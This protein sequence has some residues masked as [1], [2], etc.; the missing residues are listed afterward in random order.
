M[1]TGTATDTGRGWGRPRPRAPLLLFSPHLLRG[2][3]PRSGGRASPASPRPPCV[4]VHCTH[5]AAP[6][7]GAG[8]WGG[9]VCTS[10]D[11]SSHPSSVRCPASTGVAPPPRNAQ[12]VQAAAVRRGS[13]GERSGG[14]GRANRG[15]E[16]A[17]GERRGRGG[18]VVTEG[19]AGW[20]SAERPAATAVAHHT[21]T[22]QCQARPDDLWMEK[23]GGCGGRSRSPDD[24][25]TGAHRCRRKERG[26]ATHRAPLWG[27]ASPTQPRSVR[28]LAR[29]GGGEAR[30]V[31]CRVDESRVDQSS[32]RGAS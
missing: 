7:H 16:A 19:M 9:G 12:R 17:G 29:R 14:T 31:A 5:V 11:G 3:Q 22:Q 26:G 18:W 32:S 21:P 27:G 25:D 8:R 4:Q 30:P 2:W 24:T 1:A 28:L 6:A 23:R 13:R 10:L 20:T 15:G